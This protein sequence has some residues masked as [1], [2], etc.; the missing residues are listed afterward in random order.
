[1][2]IVYA[3]LCVCIAASLYACMFLFCVC[4]YHCW[5]SCV[6]LCFMSVCACIHHW[7][8]SPSF[9]LSVPLTLCVCI[10]AVF[11]VCLSLLTFVHVCIAILYMCIVNL[12]YYCVVSWWQLW[13]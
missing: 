6:S 2:S 1:M 7:V 10:N 13:K 8:L 11:S 3:H 9:P 12:Y 5:V 4:V